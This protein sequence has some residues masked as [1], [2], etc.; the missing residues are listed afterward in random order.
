MKNF[1]FKIFFLLVVSLGIQGNEHAL[2][3][4]PMLHS[5]S[6][7]FDSNLPN[8]LSSANSGSQ[9]QLDH[10]LGKLY[11]SAYGKNEEGTTEGFEGQAWNFFTM[12]QTSSGAAFLKA[13]N[14][15]HL[16]SLH[17]WITQGSKKKSLTEI[18]YI[19]LRV[20]NHPRAL[21]MAE[22]IEKLFKK[23][24]FALRAY[25][26]ALNRYP[27]YALTHAQYGRYLSKIGKREK[28]IESLE[29]AIKLNPK[30]ALSHAW[31]SEAYYLEGKKDSAESS[32]QLARKLGYKGEISGL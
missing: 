21:L 18:H 27:Q 9:V 28:G 24:N 3:Q 13:I 11:L 12:H 29:Q 5:H 10:S 6:F 25:K 23:R 1:T 31:L 20:P 22:V 32:G 2:T 16:R 17:L 14:N 15:A 7:Q 19:L 30:L 4:P 8:H 26:K